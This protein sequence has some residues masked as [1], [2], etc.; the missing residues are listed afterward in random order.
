MKLKLVVEMPSCLKCIMIG[1]KP[2]HQ[3]G[4]DTDPNLPS[5][6]LPPI[7][8]HQISKYMFI[9]LSLSLFFS[10]VY[11]CV[12]FCSKLSYYIYLEHLYRSSRSNSTSNGTISRSSSSTS[13]A[14][15]QVNNTNNR[16]IGF[17]SKPAK[18][19]REDSVQ[20]EIDVIAGNF[21]G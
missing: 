6:R 3:I 16:S 17:P 14:N 15:G 9:F 5:K 21:R 7:N 8:L 20:C 2:A 12:S 13:I 4:T 11:V 18:L 1:W 10:C 19:V